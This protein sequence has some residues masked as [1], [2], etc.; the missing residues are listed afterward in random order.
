RRLPS[1]MACTRATGMAWPSSTRSAGRVCGGGMSSAQGVPAVQEAR[2]VADGEVGGGDG[3]EVVPRDGE[4]DRRAGA[5]PR[6]VGGHDRRASRAGRVE[7]HLAAPVLAD[8]RRRRERGVEA[9][10]A[11]REGAG[12]GGRVGGG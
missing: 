7:E 9:L 11:G 6:A 8:E 3:A 4:R 2:G 5:D 10:G 1:C 12:G